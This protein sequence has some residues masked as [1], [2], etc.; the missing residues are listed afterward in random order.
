[1]P[2]HL[3]TETG[4]DTQTRQPGET[5]VDTIAAKHKSLQSP[6]LVEVTT[7]LCA[8]D[9][10]RGDMSDMAAG[11]IQLQTQMVTPTNALDKHRCRGSLTDHPVDADDGQAP[12]TSRQEGLP[13]RHDQRDTAGKKEKRLRPHRTAEF[14]AQ[15]CAGGG[16]SAVSALRGTARHSDST[17]AG[18]RCVGPRRWSRSAR[19]RKHSRGIDCSTSSRRSLRPR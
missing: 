8:G 11:S 15:V 9:V 19:K 2:D 4:V 14:P 3:Q 5:V 16:H 12:R 17:S 6:P 13:R 1:M 10:N 18:S 7:R